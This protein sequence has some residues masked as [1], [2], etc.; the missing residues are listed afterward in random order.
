MLTSDLKIL[1]LGSTG[2]AGREFKRQLKKIDGISTVGVARNNADINIDLGNASKVR[3]LLSVIKPGIVINAAAAVNIDLCEQNPETYNINTELP[4]LLAEESRNFD[5][6]L[7]IS[8]DHYHSGTKPY[9][10]KESE[11]VELFNEYARQKFKAE[12]YLLNCKNS[13]VLRTNIIGIRGWK[14][15]T[16]GEWALDIVDENRHCKLFNNFWTSGI[17]VGTFVKHAVGQIISGNANGL[18]NLGSS[19]VYSKLDFVLEIARQKNITLSNY[20]ITSVENIKTKRA[21][22]LGLDSSLIEN[23]LDTRLPSM[24]TV[25]KNLINAQSEQAHELQNRV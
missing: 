14:N 16:F 18:L 17:D 25:V 7:Q 21:N 20:S 24:K 6:I 13:L 1:I 5:Q 10:H 22:S 23:I 11:P 2:L 4:K 12:Q 8:T 3:E 15:P 19:N 9:A